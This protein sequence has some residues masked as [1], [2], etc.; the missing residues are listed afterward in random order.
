MLPRGG[1][2]CYNYCIFPNDIRT[3]GV[4]SRAAYRR[5]FFI[6]RVGRVLLLCGQATAQGAY[7]KRGK[8][9]SLWRPP[10]PH[11]GGPPTMTPQKVLGMLEERG[12]P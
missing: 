6:G 3:I 11:S 10:L 4:V 9:G 12:L 1:A 7:N 2:S 8:A 5:P